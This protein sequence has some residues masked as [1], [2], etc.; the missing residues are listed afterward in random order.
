[1]HCKHSKL[2]TFQYVSINTHRQTRK[3][4]SQTYLHSNMFLL[5]QRTKF[6]TNI[7]EINLHSN[8]FL[9]IPAVEQ[10]KKLV[11][12]NLHSNMFLL[13]LPCIKSKT[14]GNADL[15]SNMFLLIPISSEL[16]LMKKHIYIPICFY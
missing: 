10:A 14:L 3:Q 7:L 11:Q 12:Q 1:M 6:L 15:H 8:M 2:F 4:S 5:I 13:I 9:L 16:S